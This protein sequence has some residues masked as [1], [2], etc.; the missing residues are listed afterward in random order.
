M[1]IDYYFV[2]KGYLQIRDLYNAESDGPYYGK[3]G[4][5]WRGYVAYI[6]GILINV[7]GFAGAVGTEVPRGA[8]YLYNLNFFTGFIVSGGVYYILCRVFPV[9][10]LS[11]TG[12]WMEVGDFENPSLAYGAD[13]E[14]VAQPVSSAS[15]TEGRGDKK[16]YSI[17]NRNF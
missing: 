4:I 5:Q 11:P 6:C 13:E 17:R 14:D 1:I 15:E 10:A 12:K 7:V 9:P 3:F 2:R 8:T 16:W